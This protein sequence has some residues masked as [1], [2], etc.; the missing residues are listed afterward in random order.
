[1]FRFEF[2]PKNSLIKKHPLKRSMI[3]NN[4]RETIVSKQH[5][6]CKSLLGK[7]IGLMFQPKPKTLLFKFNKERKNSL[8]MFFVFFPIDIIFLNNNQKVVELKQ[9]LKPWQIYFPKEKSLYIIEAPIQ[10]IQN[11]KT[12]IGDSIRFK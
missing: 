9:H 5:K 11:S 2:F 6:M 12:E 8:H 7:T 10:T 3:C 4:T 1:M